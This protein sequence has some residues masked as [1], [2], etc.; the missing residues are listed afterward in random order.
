MPNF[1]NITIIGH[2][3]REPEQRT[4]GQTSITNFSVAVNTGFG[5][6]KVTTWWN[7]SLFGKQAESAAQYLHK[8]AAVCINGEPSQRPYTDKQGNEKLSLDINGK[9][10]TFATDKSDAAE[11]GV[12]APGA[13]GGGDFEDEIPF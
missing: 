12:P 3:G 1:A 13:P 7:V 11:S 4:A 10:W 9:S 5:D 2:L 6:R 8:G